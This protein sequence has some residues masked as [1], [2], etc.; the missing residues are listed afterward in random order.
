M[1]TSTIIRLRNRQL[2]DEKKVMFL[3]RSLVK[4]SSRNIIRYIV[5]M[6]CAEC[7]A[8]VNLGL[9]VHGI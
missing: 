7:Q 6:A 1:Y 8:I 5:A 3:S 2:E 9:P 4:S